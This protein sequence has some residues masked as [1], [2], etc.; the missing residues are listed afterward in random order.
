MKEFGIDCKFNILGPNKPALPQKEAL[1]LNLKPGEHVK[2]FQDG[3]IMKGTVVYD[4]Q[5]PQ[6]YQWYVNLD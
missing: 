6:M 2:V 5:L 3:I 1:G 4:E